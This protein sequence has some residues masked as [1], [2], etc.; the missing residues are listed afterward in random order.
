MAGSLWREKEQETRRIIISMT[1]DNAQKIT[2][3]KRTT[4]KT[5]AATAASRWIPKIEGEFYGDR[6][7]F[8]LLLLLLLLPFQILTAA[9]YQVMYLWCPRVAAVCPF[10]FIMHLCGI[11]IYIYILFLFLINPIVK[12]LYS[13]SYLMNLKLKEWDTRARRKRLA[14]RQ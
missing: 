9:I 14:A 4:K 2:I 6:F 12:S 3:G 13:F 11:R 5:V 1:R 7:F 8:F 10:I